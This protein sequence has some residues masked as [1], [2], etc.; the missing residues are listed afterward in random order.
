MTIPP[1]AVL[2]D[3]TDVYFRHCQNQP[4]CYFH[5]ETFRRELLAGR[6]PEYLIFAFLATA[7]RFSTDPYYANKQTEAGYH[8]ARTSWQS[9]ISHQLSKED[10]MDFQMV[11]AAN[12]LAIIDFTGNALHRTRDL[13]RCMANFS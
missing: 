1:P 13:V 6:L 7:V 3:T 10:G 4:Y 8:Y 11:Q 9:I 5:E 12:L 2:L